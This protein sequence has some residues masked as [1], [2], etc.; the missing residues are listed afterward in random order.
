MVY[1]R[2]RIRPNRTK[3]FGNLVLI[4]KK[5]RTCLSDLAVSADHRIEIK[6]SEKINKYLDFAGE[7]KKKVWNMKMT[8]VRDIY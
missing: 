5:N 8:V 2:T 3:F 6:E 4:N 7:L 1:A